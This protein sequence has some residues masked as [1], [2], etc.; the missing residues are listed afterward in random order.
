[1]KRSV[2]S[3]SNIAEIGY[4][5]ESLTLEVAF[6]NGSVYQYLGVPKSVHSG[7]M[8]AASHGKYLEWFI[9]RAGYRCQR[10]A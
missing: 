7:L 6:K 4:D 2:V 5:A 10:I 8:A 9:K 3:S 1:M